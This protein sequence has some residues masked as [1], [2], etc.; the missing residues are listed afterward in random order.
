ML[1][2]IVQTYCPSAGD[3]DVNEVSF[4]SD[5]M[6]SSSSAEQPITLS[7]TPERSSASPELPVPFSFVRSGLVSSASMPDI[8]QCLAD[9]PDD[10]VAEP[11]MVWSLGC[12]VNCNLLIGGE[13]SLT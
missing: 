8:L 1:G 13:V 3:S 9:S 2:L 11:R 12:A 10:P 4:V 5:S 6:S 7:T